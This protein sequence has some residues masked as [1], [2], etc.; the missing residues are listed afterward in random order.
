MNDNV[1]LTHGQ[2]VGFLRRGA[3]VAL[4]ASLVLAVALHRWSSQ[5]EEAFRA[6]V[7]MVAQSP[8]VD[9]RTLNLPEISFAPLHV[10]AYSVAV[11]STP[12]L[13][14]ALAS[15]DLPTT[16]SAVNALRVENLDVRALPVPQLLYIE[17]TES[18]PERAAALANAIAEQLQAWDQSRLTS[19]LQRVAQLISQRIA[20]Q[21]LFLQ[22][23]ESGEPS[24]SQT[25]TIQRS[26]LEQRN[27]L[28]SIVALSNNATSSLKILRAATPPTSGI[29]RSPVMFALLGVILGLLLVYGLMFVIE[30]FDGRLYT[31]EAVE[32]ASGLP[33]LAEIPRRKRGR[34]I[35]SDAAVT[36]QANLRS[37]TSLAHPST[38]LVMGVSAGDDSASAA[39]AVAESFAK[40]GRSTL[41]I[42]ADL[43]RPAI[44]RRYRVPE[45]NHL[46]LIACALG[47]QG[48]WQ[49]PRVHLDRQTRLALLHEN[50]ATPEDVVTMLKGLPACLEEWKHEY[51]TIVIHT[52]PL[53]AASDGLVLSESCDGVLLAIDPRTS[54][55]RRLKAAVARLRGLD[56]PL[57]AVVTTGA[58]SK[59]GVKQEY[60]VEFP[61]EVV[62]ASARS[63]AKPPRSI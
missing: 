25:D 7:A 18:S 38:I 35:G 32:R 28:D 37:A 46:S 5:G 54:N 34:S 21:Q 22:D 60:R 23:L 49:P 9:L 62:V 50:R 3:I 55:G 4:I 8:Q 48:A 11:M 61:P 30:L 29:G 33:V 41:L 19:E 16:D 59:A 56:L 57:V 17:V 43:L 52:A 45:A 27:Q 39:M 14:A 40:H 10:D 15:V 20:V 26:L 63:R 2:V 44:A 6:Q 47:Q 1:D 53:S 31:S 13:S 24:A 51:H 42:D 58:R 36:L 12:I